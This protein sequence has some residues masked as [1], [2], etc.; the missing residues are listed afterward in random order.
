[1]R[2][3]CDP[4][5]FA[6]DTVEGETIVMDLVD[7]R[8]FLL[9]SGAAIVWQ[10]VAAG[11]PLDLLEGAIQHAYGA[12]A[13]DDVRGFV[14]DLR[15][16]GLLDDVGEEAG[17]GA[18][19]AAQAVDGARAPEDL[20]LPAELGPLTITAYDDMTS[21]ITMDPIH[22]VDPSRGWPFDAPS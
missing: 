18:A 10:H 17:E 8:L 11:V 3:R 1:M 4:S 20:T 21:I 7:G 13:R 19:E 14:A 9:E 12:A 22:D 15:A 5:R 2:Y 6:V 16:R